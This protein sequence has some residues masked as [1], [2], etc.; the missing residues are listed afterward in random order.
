MPDMN[1]EASR[2]LEDWANARLIKS[3]RKYFLAGI[4]FRDSWPEYSTEEIEALV[5]SG[6]C[7]EFALDYIEKK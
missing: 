3:A 1:N 2:I 7:D 6:K 5:D 4:A